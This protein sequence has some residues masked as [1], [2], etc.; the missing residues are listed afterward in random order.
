V[1]GDADDVHPPGGDVYDEQDYNRRKV[2]VS[3]WKKS[4]ASRPLA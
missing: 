3:T 2:T 4:A 1:C